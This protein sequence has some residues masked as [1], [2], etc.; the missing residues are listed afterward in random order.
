MGMAVTYLL[1]HHLFR[2][3]LMPDMAQFWANG[4]QFMTTMMAAMPRQG[5]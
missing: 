4:A 2:L 5:K 3:Y 1:L